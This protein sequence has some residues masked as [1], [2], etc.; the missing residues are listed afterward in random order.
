MPRV[1]K[2]ILKNV[3]KLGSKITYAVLL[4][5]YAY[6]RPG[7]PR[8]AKTTI[9]GAIGYLLS[10]IDAIPDITPLVGFTDDL[11]VI[12]TGLI[13]I[14]AY[15]NDDVKQKAKARLEKIFPNANYEEIEIID[16]KLQ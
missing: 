10:P 7:T 5:F 4:L 3:E 13:T 11:G 8:W 2:F 16:E 6:K 15:I 14:A 9:L 1:I 12:M